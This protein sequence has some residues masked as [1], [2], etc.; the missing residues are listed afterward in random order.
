MD[1]RLILFYVL[2]E[3][4]VHVI[5]FTLNQKM[6]L[7]VNEDLNSALNQKDVLKGM[8]ER[9]VLIA[10]LMAGYPQTIIA[11]GALKIGTRIKDDK[12]KVS[13]DY[14]LVGNLISILAAIAFVAI[15]KEI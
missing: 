1:P 9:F 7:A 5:F 8:L 6:L 3:V 15:I 13:N 10:G 11:F 4:V 14:F 12:N 2:M